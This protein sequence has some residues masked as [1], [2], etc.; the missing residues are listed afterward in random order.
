MASGQGGSPHAWECPRVHVD[1]RLC[2]RW[3]PTCV[4][5]PA[6]PVVVAASVKVAPH[7]RGN[8]PDYKPQARSGPSVIP[9][10]ALSVMPP[11]P[12]VIPALPPLSFPPAPSVI[13]AGC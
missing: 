7:M 12:H 6:G 5:M 9:A 3:L 8:A 11:A 13:P 4:G 1:G 2:P 10:L